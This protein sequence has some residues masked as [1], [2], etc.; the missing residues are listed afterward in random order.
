MSEGDRSRAFLLGLAV[1]GLI[2]C[3]LTLWLTQ[4][5][6]RKLR[7][8]GIDIG[9]R[10]GELGSLVK[11]KGEE[12]LS[13]AREVAELAIEEG[14]ESGRKARYEMEERFKKDEEE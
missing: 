9:G 11:E 10:L 8:R 14:R 4:R 5:V 6:R 7:E 13:R 1:G 12:F 3:I 2:G